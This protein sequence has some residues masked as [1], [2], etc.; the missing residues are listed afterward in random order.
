MK[1]IT[2][3]AVCLSLLFV[4]ALQ[5]Q[6]NPMIPL[7]QSEQPTSSP[8]SVATEQATLPAMSIAPNDDKVYYFN[9]TYVASP[10]TLG[11][12][13]DVYIS[14]NNS[15][16]FRE[17]R[18]GRTTKIMDDVRSVYTIAHEYRNT[19]YF[20][21][22]NNELWVMGNNEY[23]SVGDDTGMNQSKPVFVMNDVANLYFDR[24]QAF[25][26]TYALKTDKSRWGWGRIQ[27]TDRNTYAP[28][29]IDDYFNHNQQLLADHISMR[30]GNPETYP[31][32]DLSNEIIELL[33]GR[34][35]IISSIEVGH[36]S[37]GSIV[38]TR[39]DSRYYA[40]T[41]DG[42]LWGWGHNA[43][44]LGDGTRAT[45]D[46]PVKIAENVKRLLP[47]Y[48]ITQ[49]NDWYIYSYAY[50]DPVFTPR[51]HLQNV[52][53]ASSLVRSQVNTTGT[54]YTPDGKFCHGVPGARLNVQV[55]V[56]D[57]K[58]PSIVRAA[59]GHII[60]P[61]PE[62]ITRR[63]LE[64]GTAN[65]QPQDNAPVAERV[66]QNGGQPAAQPAPGRPVLRALGREFLR[67]NGIR[68]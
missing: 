27:G 15:A 20:V 60:A 11:G 51:M 43:G 42:I 1:K 4:A 29:K 17:A 33:G 53:Y 66:N 12:G 25:R 68:L 18:G 10:A 34:D 7:P 50:G 24:H 55:R 39:T 58:L 36:S 41:K 44:A 62:Q 32:I 54:W 57:I 9:S 59:D 16:Y 5:A 49:S 67:Q 2:F 22:V 21:K 48:F 8:L 6:M 30:N 46:R 61:R 26:T 56:N 3:L 47:D 63:E 40:V 45:R 31:M 64:S 37:I 28:V 13:N 35:N 19:Y 14:S 38:P 52:L 65:L 23:G